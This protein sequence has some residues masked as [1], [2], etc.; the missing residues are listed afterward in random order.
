MATF[1]WPTDKLTIINSALSQ[2]GDRLVSAADDGS[3]EWGACSPAYERGLAYVIESHSWSWTTNVRTLQP[4]PTPPTDDRYDTAYPLPPDLVHLILV[5]INDGPGRW[6]IENNLLVV[7]AKGG[8]PPPS[9]PTVPFKVDIKGIF[10]TN[11][12]P[13][14]ATPTVI[15]VLQMFVM[16]G[17]YRSMKKDVAEA[18][19]LYGEAMKMLDLAKARHD[20]QK[21]KRQIF[22]SRMNE[23]R[24]HRR[25]GSPTPPGLGGPGW[26]GT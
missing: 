15:V 9:V 7:N 10:S 23:S 5:R 8:P 3:V 16:S 18:G 19:K 25:P 6:D 24:R 22:I 14:N 11:S 17:I 4:S 13:V 1:E 21:P 2:T 26:P 12:D 20:Q